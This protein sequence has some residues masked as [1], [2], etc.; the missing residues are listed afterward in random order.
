MISAVP[1]QAIQT[2]L[3]LPQVAT[4]Q[5]RW[6]I[7]DHTGKLMA[8]GVSPPTGVSV[9]INTVLPSSA[10]IPLDGSKY[11]ISATDGTTSAAEWFSVLSPTDP[12]QNDHGIEMAYLQGRAFTDSIILPYQPT[13]LTV[14]INLTAGTVVRTDVSVDVAQY[15][16]I[17]QSFAYK[18]GAGVVDTQTGSTL[19]TGIVTWMITDPSGNESF[20][21]HP[22]YTITTRTMLFING[23]R[24]LVDKIRL[25]DVHQYLQFT[26]SDLAHGMNRGIDYVA[27]SPPLMTLFPLD[28]APLSMADYIIKAGAVDIIQAQYLAEG[29]GAFDFQGLGV[30]L[31]VDR[32]QYLESMLNSLKGDL[33]KLTDVK[34]KWLEMGKPTGD[35]RVVGMR[36][37]GILGLSTGVYSNMPVYG[38]PFIFGSGGYNFMR[39]YGP[40]F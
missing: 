8:Q 1:G 36:P 3:T 26:M 38:R 40:R 27:Q 28:Q 20:E 9:V 4:K 22:F 5:I 37:I 18:Y 35:V 21:L 11:V 15:T 29:M 14:S 33:D 7:R 10:V 31:N 19:G 13:A 32:T 25:G 12:V 16:R 2:T 34:K 39:G 17:G 23:I 6:I 24:K 30:Q